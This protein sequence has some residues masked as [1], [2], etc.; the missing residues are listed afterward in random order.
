MHRG[1]GHYTSVQGVPR[2][3][4]DII[5]GGYFNSSASRGG[6][7]EISHDIAEVDDNEESYSHETCSRCMC[8]ALRLPD[9]RKGQYLESSLPKYS[10]HIPLSFKDKSV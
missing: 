6:G 4:L 7:Q 8:G 5:S 1:D 9:S 2:D 10:E 3:N